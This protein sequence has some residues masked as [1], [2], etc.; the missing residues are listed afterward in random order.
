VTPCSGEG[1]STTWCCDGQNTLCCGQVGAITIAAT[2]GPSS[3]STTFLSTTFSST[4]FLYFSIVPTRSSTTS[5]TMNPTNTSNGNA[6]SV[7][8]EVGIGVGV[9]LAGIVILGS[10]IWF[11]LRRIHKHRRV[12][13]DRIE[14][15]IYFLKPELDRNTSGGLGGGEAAKVKEPQ[16]PYELGGQSRS[17]LSA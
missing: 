11:M 16:L 5:N 1:N 6:L 2:I 8:T 10:I 9:L 15:D 13:V 14:H 17:E 7:G 4:T 12:D 3:S